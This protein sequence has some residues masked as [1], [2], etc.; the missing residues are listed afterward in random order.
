MANQRIL[1]SEEMVGHGHGTKAD[2]LNRAYNVEHEEDGVHEL[3]GDS[4][5]EFTSDGTIHMAK[6]SGF[7][8]SL[9]VDQ[10][11]VRVNP[12]LVQFDTEEDDVRGEFNVGTYT[13]TAAKLGIYDV[14]AVIQYKENFADGDEIQLYIYKNAAVYTKHKLLIAAAGTVGS[15]IAVRLP[16]AATNTIDIRTYHSNAANRELDKDYCRFSVAKIA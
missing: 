14:S 11:I 2:T 1:A 3:I 16:L 4:A 6:Q 15:S 7:S 8:A 5:I 10:D 9:S 12:I 13:F